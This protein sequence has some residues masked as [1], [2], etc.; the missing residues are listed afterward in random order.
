M[1]TFAKYVLFLAVVG[2]VAAPALQAQGKSGKEKVDLIHKGHIISV[3]PQAVPAHL[4]HGDQLVTP[5]TTTYTVE[6]TVVTGLP[7]PS[8]TTYTATISAG[9]SYIFS[10]IL[11]GLSVIALSNS[12]DAEFSY[13]DYS[14]TVSNVDGNASAEIITNYSN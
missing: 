14:V 2:L 10:G 11:T 6:V 13:D 12:G 5:P 3:A 9:G 4:A 7:L 1:K 8:S